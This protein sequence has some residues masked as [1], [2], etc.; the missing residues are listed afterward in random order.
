MP[1]KAMRQAA[2]E[3]LITQ[4]VNDAVEAERAGRGGNRNNNPKGNYQGNNR[5]QQYNNRRQ[6][7]A[8][9]LTNSLAE[10]VKY[11]GHK[12]LCNNCKKHHNGNCWATCYNCGRPGH[13]AKDYKR[14]S[15]PVCYECG[16]KGHTRNYCLKKKNP[17][18]EEARGRA[19]VIKEADKDQGPNIVMGTF[20]LNNRYAIVL[21]DSC[22]DKSSMNT[23]FSHLIDIDPVRLNTSYEVKLADG[24]VASTNI[25]EGSTCTLQE[26]DLSSQGR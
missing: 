12:P 1:P 3:R 10:Q 16:E 14:K 9:A 20:S 11:K 18:G 15:T 26:Q 6:G 13:L 24:R 5:H 8:Q 21:F 25:V 4:R 7:N 17:Q 2:I 19:Y 22:S 23:S